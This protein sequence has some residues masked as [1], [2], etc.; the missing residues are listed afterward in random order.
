M[1]PTRVGGHHAVLAVVVPGRHAPQQRVGA[2]Q[3]VHGREVLVEV[4]REVKVIWSANTN[5]LYIELQI[6]TYIYIH[7]HIYIY[8][9]SQ[10][11]S[12]RRSRGQGHLERKHKQVI[13][14]VTYTH[15]YIYTHTYI[16]NIS[17]PRST[18]RSQARG[19]GRLERKH[20]Q[21]YIA[22]DTHIYIY[23]HTHRHRYIQY[24]MAA[25]YS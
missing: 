4:G 23:I 6:H 7:T 19:Q 25:K 1:R 10:P 11:R 22:T 2:Q 24:I 18:R 17:W 3:G 14:R 13:Y 9:I 21:V 16:Y 15:I 8:N 12:T 5:R 20:K